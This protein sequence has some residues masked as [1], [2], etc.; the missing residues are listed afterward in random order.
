MNKTTGATRKD[1]GTGMQRLVNK[2]GGFM[3]SNEDIKKEELKKEIKRVRNISTG[4]AATAG[5]VVGYGLGTLFGW[6]IV[7]TLA[8]SCLLG[9]CSALSFKVVD[10][11]DDEKTSE[12]I[13]TFKN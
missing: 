3:K 1:L 10:C 7:G 8:S 12:E 13:Q 4:V 6:P 5:T 9:G 2:L 11:E